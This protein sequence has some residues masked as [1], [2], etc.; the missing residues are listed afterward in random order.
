MCSYYAHFVVVLGCAFFHCNDGMLVV[1]SGV[2]FVSC[3]VQL[4]EVIFLSS[5]RHFLQSA[6][7]KTKSFPNQNSSS[8]RMSHL[9]QQGTNNLLTLPKHTYNTKRK[10]RFHHEVF[11]VS[12]LPVCMFLMMPLLTVTHA[13]WFYQP[14]RI[15]LC[16]VRR[17]GRSPQNCGLHIIEIW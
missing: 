16:G 2:L 13:Q 1:C 6:H 11:E 12:C 4:R 14:L 7:L 8:R 9:T 3:W 15:C 10:R 5:L 17:V